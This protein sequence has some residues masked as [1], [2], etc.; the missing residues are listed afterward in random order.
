MQHSM[1]MIA[2]ALAILGGCANGST[3]PAQPAPPPTPMVIAAPAETPASPPLVSI[4]PPPD[5]AAP[6][7]TKET[8]VSIEDP[9]SDAKRSVSAKIGDTVAVI[10]PEYPGMT[11]KV[12]AV[13]KTLGHPKEELVPGFL[14]PGTPGR[15][16]VW[17]TGLP[18]P[19]DLKGDHVVTFTGIPLAGDAG[20]KPM[21]VVLTIHLD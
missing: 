11:W 8:L 16:F 13:D 9:L 21:K 18:T 3:P 19:L 20:K 6:S 1:K 10:L 17:P 14:G 5:A 12:T 2:A 4:P 7:A 15:K